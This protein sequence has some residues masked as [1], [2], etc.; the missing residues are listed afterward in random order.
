MPGHSTTLSVLGTFILWLGWYGFNPGSTLAITAV[1]YGATMARAAV[2]TTISAAMCGISTL[3]LER[4]LGS[5]VWDVA[6]VCNGVLAGLVSITAGCATI[7]TSYA[8]VVGLV[9]AFVYF[10]ASKLLLYRL[11]VDD[12]LDAFA[13][14]GACGFWGVLANALVADPLYTSS[15]YAWAGDEVVVGYETRQAGQDSTYFSVFYGGHKMLGAA[16]VALLSTIAWVVGISLPMFVALRKAGLFRVSAEVEEAG[17]D[18]SKHGGTAYPS[19]EP[20][21]KLYTSM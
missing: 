18:T 5:R 12:P 8:A 19:A 6:A 20:T 1:G 14:H 13:V 11:K 10:G 4:S 2:T 17:M 15:F 3:L 7:A 16:V 21:A 9:G